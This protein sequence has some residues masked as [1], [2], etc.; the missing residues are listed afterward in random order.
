M[1]LQW[2]PSLSKFARVGPGGCTG[3]ASIY[4]PHSGAAS[5]GASPPVFRAR[6]RRTDDWF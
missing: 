4:L 6:W 1:D 5:C 3:E 2:R